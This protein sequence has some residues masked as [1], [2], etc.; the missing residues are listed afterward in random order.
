MSSLTDSIIETV[1]KISTE[2]RPGILDNL[3]LTAAIEW[4]TEEFASRTGID[5]RLDCLEEF[6]DLDQARTTACFRILQ[7]TLTNV[8]RHANATEVHI[9]L[10]RQ[11]DNLILEICDNGKGIS[12]KEVRDRTSIGLLGMKE[13]AHAMGGVFDIDGLPGKGTRVL[14]SIPLDETEIR[15]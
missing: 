9:S 4:Q 5:C 3:G 12:D 14:V 11:A 1:Q 10:K 7:E 13:R 15:Y 6:A 8:A 2:L